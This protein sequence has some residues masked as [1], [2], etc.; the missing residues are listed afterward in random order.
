M[1]LRMLLLGRALLGRAFLGVALLCV[2][3]LGLALLLV[4]SSVLCGH[5]LG[6]FGLSNGL[7]RFGGGAR[8]F[9]GGARGLGSGAR[10]FGSGARSFGGGARDFGD[11]SGRFRTFA[12]ATGATPGISSSTVTFRHP[13][14]SVFSSFL[15]SFMSFRF[16]GWCFTRRHDSVFSVGKIKH[17]FFLIT[18]VYPR[19]IPSHVHGRTFA[20]VAAAHAVDVL[21]ASESSPRR[22]ACLPGTPWNPAYL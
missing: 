16:G 15:L 20:R 7:G 13:L 17:R 1:T 18:F 4:T 19:T 2:A 22:A 8:G 10:S 3:L 14:S 9:G 5:S 21:L 11:N 6:R 12:R